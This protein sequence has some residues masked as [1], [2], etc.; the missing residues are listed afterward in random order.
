MLRQ[1]YAAALSALYFDSRLEYEARQRLVLELT[2][3]YRQHRAEEMRAIRA[4]EQADSKA[5]ELP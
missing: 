1:E 2:S 4:Q 3:E 5:R